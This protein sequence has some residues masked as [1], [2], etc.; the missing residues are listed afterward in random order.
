MVT[1]CLLDRVVKVSRGL[2]VQMEQ[3]DKMEV[4]DCLDHL[5]LRYV[6]QQVLLGRA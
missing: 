6:Y 5:D 2:L 4:M 3:T 1:L